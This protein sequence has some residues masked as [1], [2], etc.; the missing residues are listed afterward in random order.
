MFYLILGIDIE[1]QI[2]NG[3]LFDFDLEV[4]PI[5]EVLVGKTIYIYNNISKTPFINMIKLLKPLF[6]N[7]TIF[8]KPYLLIWQ[9]L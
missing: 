1:T 8:L 3:D 7:M 2:E 6:S 9:Y 5:L 4:E